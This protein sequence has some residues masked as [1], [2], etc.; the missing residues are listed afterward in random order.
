MEGPAGK[1]VAAT[2]GAGLCLVVL[3]GWGLPTAGTPPGLDLRLI[4]VPPGELALSRIG[5]LASTHAMQAGGDPVGGALEIEN[6]SGRPLRVAP[7]V[8][9][10]RAELAG[11]VR[12]RLSGR[13]RSATGSALTLQRPDPDVEIGLPPGGSAR[14]EVVAWIAPGVG[15]Y[16]GGILDLTLELRARPVRETGSGR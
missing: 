2:V 11:K 14:V 12:L 10:S 9:P 13:G 3:A 1:L 16:R 6:I 15:G 4:A 5:V 8:L 7:V